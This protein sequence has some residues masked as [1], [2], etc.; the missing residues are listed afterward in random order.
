MMPSDHP[1]DEGSTQVGST[2]AEETIRVPAVRYLEGATGHAVLSLLFLLATAVLFARDM[3]GAALVTGLIAC[4]VSINGLSIYLWDRLRTK[5][6]SR[7]R[8]NDTPT[9][10][11]LTPPR[12]PTRMKAEMAAGA[13]MVGGFCA[14]LGLAVATFR[15]LEVHQAVI[16]AVGTLG[17]ANIAALGVAYSRS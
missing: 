17:L 6:V 1:E 15:V 11:T 16:L 3:P 4:G 8:R 7:F 14:L 12:I 5:F 13:V 10:R 9:T 2:V